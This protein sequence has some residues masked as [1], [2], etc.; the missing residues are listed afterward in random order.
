MHKVVG[1]VGA[2]L[3]KTIKELSNCAEEVVDQ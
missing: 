2:F 3:D 1:D